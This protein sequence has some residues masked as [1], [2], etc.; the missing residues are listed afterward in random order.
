M[1]TILYDAAEGVAT[2]TLNRPH[3]RNAWTGR[4]EVEYRAAL[5]QADRDGDV[6][7]V[8]LTGAGD[9]FCIG[10]DAQALDGMRASGTYDSGVREPLQQ[11]GRGDDPDLRTRHGFLWG[12]S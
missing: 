8:V 5:D 11:P 2:V 12:L 9:A 6:R 10:A 3:R 7:V 1:D 4:M